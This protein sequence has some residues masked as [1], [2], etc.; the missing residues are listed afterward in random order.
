MTYIVL[1]SVTV[2]DKLFAKSLFDTVCFPVGRY[3]EDI[4]V[5][6]RL[7]HIAKKAFYTKA[8]LYHYCIREGS[9]TQ[10]N[11]IQVL[12]DAYE[13]RKM[14]NQ[15]MHEWGF[16]QLA[17]DT[18]EKEAFYQLLHFGSFGPYSAECIKRLKSIQGFPSYFS[19]RQKIM[20]EVF[21]V[22]PTLFDVISILWG[23]RRL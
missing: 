2:W 17:E 16:H 8:T 21:R 19:W 7:A 12:A 3:S 4:A 9:I 11:N 5:M 18:L 22:S 10:Q 13:M 20:L 15:D 14:Q 6:H 23:K 1:K